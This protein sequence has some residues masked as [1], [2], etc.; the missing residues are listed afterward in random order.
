MTIFSVIFYWNLPTAKKLWHFESLSF[1]FV[2]ISYHANITYKQY[3]QNFILISIINFVFVY[4]L[5]AL[6]IHNCI[7]VIYADISPVVQYVK[8]I[9]IRI[10][11]LENLISISMRFTY[12]AT[13]N[14]L[15][16]I[17]WWIMYQGLGKCVKRWQVDFLIEFSMNIQIGWKDNSL[18][19]YAFSLVKSKAE[20]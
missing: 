16:Q 6:I 15:T 18:I 17:T 1:Y 11:I 14:V 3:S 4:P 20:H 13:G 5:Y 7:N 19:H 9:T 10:Y 2:I 12:C 8:Y